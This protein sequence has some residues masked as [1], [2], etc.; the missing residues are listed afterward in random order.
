Y[1]LYFII[2]L[3]SILL[4]VLLVQLTSYPTQ[5]SS[6]LVEPGAHLVL[7]AVAG[8]ETEVGVEPVARRPALLQGDDL[9][10]L[11]VLQRRVQRHHHQIE[12]H[13][14]ELQSREKLVC[15]LLLEKKKNNT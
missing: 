15:R 5:R 3:F 6:D 8:Q 2:K 12:E 4:S 10:G 7:C 14:S 11:A 13:T 9:H 1:I